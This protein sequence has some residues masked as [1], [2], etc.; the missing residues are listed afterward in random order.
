MNLNGVEYYYIRNVQGD[1][2]GL[3]DKTGTQV[4]GYIYDTWGKL[5]SI[6]GTLASSVGVK[7]PYRYK[8][9]R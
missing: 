1:I 9:Y 5:I 3:H 4:V 8:G 2:I 7:N 6:T